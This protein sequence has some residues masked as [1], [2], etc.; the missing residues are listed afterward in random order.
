[1]E[2]TEEQRG[3]GIDEGREGRKEKSHMHGRKV[4]NKARK[5]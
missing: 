3:S 1:V 2:G 5:E 4:K